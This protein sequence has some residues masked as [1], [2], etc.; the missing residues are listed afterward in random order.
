M[1]EYVRGKK[2]GNKKARLIHF[3]SKFALSNI[4]KFKKI[5]HLAT[6]NGMCPY[7]F[8]AERKVS[9]LHLL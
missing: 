4:R 5:C 1:Q 7:L 3:L 2:R 8:T 6:K 9:S